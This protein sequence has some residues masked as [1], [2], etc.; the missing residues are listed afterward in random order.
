MVM[1]FVKEVDGVKLAPI[2]IKNKLADY[3]ND[4]DTLVNTHTALY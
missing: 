3:E 2:A 4:N 1:A